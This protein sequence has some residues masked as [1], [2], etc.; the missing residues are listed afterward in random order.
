MSCTMWENNND[1]NKR[2][3][4]G[5]IRGSW[6]SLFMMMILI[7]LMI[8][9]LLLITKNFPCQT[10]VGLY[11]ERL[12][13]RHSNV[14]CVAAS[15]NNRQYWS[16]EIRRRVPTFI[17]KSIYLPPSLAKSKCQFPIFIKATDS[18]HSNELTP[19]PKF[20]GEIP[21]KW[22]NLTLTLEIGTV[23]FSFSFA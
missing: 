17:T 18:H 13:G 19:R 23:Y 8:V 16:V 2:V 5:L 3:R 7:I 10:M 14:M 12:F 22:K 4:L 9:A 6:N 1:Q 15:A 11:F 20:W 21:E